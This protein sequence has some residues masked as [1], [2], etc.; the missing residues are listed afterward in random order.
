MK[1]VSR[2]SV[3]ILLIVLSASSII[4]VC[5]VCAQVSKPSP[6]EFTVRYLD[7]SYDTEPIYGVNQFTGKTVII[8]ASEHVDK[9]TVEVTIKN[10]P[11]TPYNDSN[12]K[13]IGLYYNFRF[14]GPYGDVWSYY[15]FTPGG[16]S[17]IPYNG[18]P[19][20]TGDLSPRIST[21][22]STYTVT[23]VDLGILLS[24]AS[25][26][27]G[28]VT[29]PTEGQIEFQAQNL[30]GH[31]E[32]ECSGLLAGSFYD[33]TGQSSNWSSTQ[34]VTFGENSGT[35]TS[36]TS[37]PTPTVQPVE[38]TP[39][40]TATAT[41]A[42]NPTQ[43]PMQPNTETNVLLGLGLKDIIIVLLAVVVS[44]MALAILLFRRKSISSS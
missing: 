16:R 36:P 44:G 14:K 1:K 17:A 30:I 9:R 26:Y 21:S 18:Y 5:S 23:S 42:Q 31:I 25:G 22:D 11:F 34:T 10:Q 28:S 38:P 33:F 19:W 40:S 37:N 12:G 39:K 13:L 4:V 27:S 35:S 15:P 43:V 32:S 3:G 24:I 8:E 6:P 2:L 29:F 7:N 20:G 41:L